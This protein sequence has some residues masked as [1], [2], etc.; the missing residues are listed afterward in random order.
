MPRVSFKVAGRV[1]ALVLALD[2]LGPADY[3]LDDDHPSFLGSV[4]V[5]D[6]LADFIVAE[7]LLPD[8]P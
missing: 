3:F 2:G 1:A 7:R 4:V 5:A 6:R 8:P